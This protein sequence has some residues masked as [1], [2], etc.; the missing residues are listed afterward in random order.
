MNDLAE[1]IAQQNLNRYGFGMMVNSIE[2]P[3]T[4]IARQ[5]PR[6]M[7]KILL[8]EIRERHYAQNLATGVSVVNTY[9]CVASQKRIDKLSKIRVVPKCR[10]S[11]FG[12]DGMT[13]TFD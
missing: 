5:N 1:Y 8:E 6:L 11:F 9:L 12:P 4:A 7:G 2:S 10:E 13:I 3:E